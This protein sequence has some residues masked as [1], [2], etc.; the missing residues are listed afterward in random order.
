MATVNTGSGTT[1]IAMWKSTVL[2][3]TKE[4]GEGGRLVA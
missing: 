3:V 4:L 2:L 1:D